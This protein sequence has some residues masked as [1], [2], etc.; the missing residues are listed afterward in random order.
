M[1]IIWEDFDQ[2]T[3]ILRGWHQIAGR[4]IKALQPAGCFKE[5]MHKMHIITSYSKH[6]KDKYLT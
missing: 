3:A 5:K 4:N 1:K 2:Q 6:I